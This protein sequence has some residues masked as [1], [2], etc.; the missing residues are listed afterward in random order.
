VD[1]TITEIA[2]DIFRISTFVPQAHLTF[3]RFLLRAE[4][5]AIFHTG[6]R[7][8]FEDT[9]DAIASLVP[10]EKLR[11][12]TFG[13]YEADECGAMN[14]L[15]G[16]APHAT[17]AHGAIGV[18]LSINDQ[19]ARQPRYLADGEVLDLGGKRLRRIETPQI[20]HCPDAGLFF[21]EVSGTL[22]CGDLF[23]QTGTKAMTNEDIIAPAVDLE[24]KFGLSANTPL[25]GPTIANLA[26]LNP[27]VLALMH[28]PA[29]YGDCSKA[30]LELGAYY[31]NRHA[32]IETAA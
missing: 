5:P 21:E 27:S 10:V 3:N 7:V 1:T 13:H 19:A 22:L 11:W 31:T 9:R 16:A 32:K 15:L 25:T 20:P 23:T 18:M 2:P 8:L 28:G 14:D 4:E 29:Y 6:M 26:L 24:E 12:I 17:V 30:L